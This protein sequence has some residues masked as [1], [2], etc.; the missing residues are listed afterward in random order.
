MK[1]TFL[2]I[3]LLYSFI[4]SCKKTAGTAATEETPATAQLE[5]I[6]S[7]LIIDWN[8]VHFRLIKNTSGVGH[9]AFS[10][11]FAYTGIAL[12]ESL[13]NGDKHFK[14]IVPSLN[15]SI[16][17]PAV[18]KGN[19]LYYP[20][21]AN[22]ALADMLRYFYNGKAGNTAIIDSLEMAYKAK[23]DAETKNNFDITN[24]VFFGREVAA[25]VI[26]WAKQDGATAANI[27]YSPMGEGYWEPTPPA[28]AQPAAPGWGNVRTILPGSINNTMPPAP[29]V[30]S[31]AAGSSFYNMAREVYDI[32]GSLT[33][34]QKDIANFWDDLPN[35]KY[36]SAFGHWFHIL[37][38]VLQNEKTPLMD[39]AEAFLRL[40]ITMNEAGI[41]CWKAKYTYHVMRPVTYIRKYMNHETWNSF[42][43]TPAHPE[44]TAAHAA[45]SGAAAAA[46]ETVFG[47]NYAFTDD[48][49]SDI[50]MAPRQY[51]SFDAAGTEAGISRV[52]GGI[53]YRPSVEA[54]KIL[55]KKT[56]ENVNSILQTVK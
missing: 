30:F 53:H 6:S 32:S 21:A 8:N 42:I 48:T 15:G 1:K 28:F 55:G 14:S 13:V 56:A 10:R 17:L 4:A 41:S 37:N 27:P 44:Y 45:L 36:I 18:E 24:A 40:G 9:V 25:A 20:A 26:D 54:G 34:Q 7:Q 52:Y 33:Q 16:T 3:T 38:G 22:A 31:A 29:A 39:G 23:Y 19:H 49:Y 35:G 46:L 5:K 50:G 43:G 2:V 47:K 11:H 12:Y 51:N